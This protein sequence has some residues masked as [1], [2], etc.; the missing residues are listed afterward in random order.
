M[1]CAVLG[2]AHKGAGRQIASTGIQ[3]RVKQ[4]LTCTRLSPTLH[5]PQE[6]RGV[7][8]FFFFFFPFF[9]FFF[10]FLAWKNRFLEI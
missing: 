6:R 9:T 10:T 2:G 4:A 5:A 7:Q 1:A 8:L 3:R